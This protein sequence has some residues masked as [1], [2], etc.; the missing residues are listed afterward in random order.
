MLKLVQEHI[1]YMG[2][3]VT[4]GV[5]IALIGTILNWMWYETEILTK[6]FFCIGIIIIFTP[7]AGEVITSYRSRRKYRD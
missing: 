7:I 5:C 4:S 2:L 3:V 1:M 6:Y